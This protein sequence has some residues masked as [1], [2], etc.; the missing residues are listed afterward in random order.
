MGRK[1]KNLGITKKC[2]YFLISG[3]NFNTRLTSDRS[4]QDQTPQDDTTHNPDQ[5]C[6][7]VS[8][9]LIGRDTHDMQAST[10]ACGLSLRLLLLLLLLLLCTRSCLRF[11]CHTKKLLVRF[12]H[13]AS[14]KK[15]VSGRQISTS[16][17]KSLVVSAGGD[18]SQPFAVFLRA[19]SNR[20]EK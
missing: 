10:H 7:S 16:K 14:R 17:P 8:G 4:R 2:E 5:L 1:Q 12:A 6:S 9:L 20:T 13:L 11:F 18:A 3:G 19:T 15:A